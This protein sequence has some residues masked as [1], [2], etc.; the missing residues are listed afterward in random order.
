MK[1]LTRYGLG[2]MVTCLTIGAP[3]LVSAE[4]SQREKEEIVEMVVARI[5][6]DPTIAFEMLA[7]LKQSARADVDQARDIIKTA[8]R[9]I[10]LVE[11][12]PQGDIVIMD[13]SDYGCEI[14]NTQSKAL[15]LAADKDKRIKIVL[16]DLPRSGDDATQASIDLVAAASGQKDW[17]SIRQ[18]YLSGQIKPEMRIV[19]LAEG[20]SYPSQADRDLAQIALDKNK[21]LAER[22]GI[23][24]GP[25][26]ILIAGDHVQLLPPSVTSEKVEEII[27]GIQAKQSDAE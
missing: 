20:H 15:L 26:A 23:E 6:S 10:E 14:C 5:K 11:G 8:P 3:G 9:M 18:S 1:I 12:N 27:A 7:A 21:A 24:T 19:A 2:A 16:R 22:S 4:M 25:A 13:F 17:R